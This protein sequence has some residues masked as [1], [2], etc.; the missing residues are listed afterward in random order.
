MFKFSMS[1]LE[2]P[3][4]NASDEIFSTETT[5]AENGDQTS[6][7]EIP[8]ES[9]SSV[10]AFKLPFVSGEACLIETE[11]SSPSNNRVE[12]SLESDNRPREFLFPK[13]TFDPKC[14]KEDKSYLVVGGVRGFGFE[15][16]RWLLQNGA[17]TVICTA[18]SAAS[19][20]KM[21]EVASIEKETGAR[22]LLRQADV[23]SWQDMLGIV[24]ELE[25]LPELAGIVFTAMVLEDQRIKDAELETCARVVST[26]VQGTPVF[27][28]RTEID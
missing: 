13:L 3:T 17:K 8:S 16:V 19:E 21:A 10:Q 12:I 2:N 25:G 27:Q 7:E 6:T 9:N 14:L 11:R 1:F 4:I 23:T 24:R 26:K 15:V 22:I 20:S 5:R 28:F 18:R